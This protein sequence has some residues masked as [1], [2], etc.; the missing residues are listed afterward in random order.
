MLFSLYL[1]PWVLLPCHATVHV[2]HLTNLDLIVL[3]PTDDPLYPQGTVRRRLSIRNAIGPR[4]A[5]TWTERSYCK[6]WGAYIHGNVV[7]DSQAQTIQNFTLVM[8]GTG[9]HEN[10]EESGMSRIKREDLGSVGRKLDST[11][12][13]ALLQEEANDHNG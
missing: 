8:A 6:A 11:E 13:R 10:D 1:R 5:P 12:I 7:S 2:P 3:R 9:K 4:L